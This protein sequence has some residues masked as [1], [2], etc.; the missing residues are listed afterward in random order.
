MIPDVRETQMMRLQRPETF[1]R[2]QTYENG[3]V[4]ERVG[5][6]EAVFH[7]MYVSELRPSDDGAEDQVVVLKSQ[8]LVLR[9]RACSDVSCIALDDATNR[10]HTDV[11]E[12]I[13]GRFSML[14]SEAKHLDDTYLT[15]LP[16]TKGLRSRP[17]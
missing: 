14:I 6:W 15:F 16:A 12:I 2:R 3:R 11:W 1:Q 10:D 13:V 7:I 8:Y 5:F 9:L 17:L 4:M